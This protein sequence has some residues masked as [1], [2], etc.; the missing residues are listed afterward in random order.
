LG[1][2]DDGTGKYTQGFDFDDRHPNAAG[3]RELAYSIVPTLF[4]ALDKGKPIPTMP[5]G[6]TGFARVSEGATP[7]TFTP[8]ET[9]HPFAMSF[10]VRA[11][12]DGTVA[13][14]S[15]STLAAKSEI[16]NSPR[17]SSTFESM[18]RT[19]DRPFT[20]TIGVQNGKWMFKAASGSVVRS[21]VAADSQWHNAV[22]SHYTARG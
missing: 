5:S 15:G 2:V 7:F 19:A 6:P 18:S 8:Q 9:M 22:L 14:I 10:V 11:Q 12:A 13:S 21:N 3:H 20:E 1:A 16:K 4:D 17:G